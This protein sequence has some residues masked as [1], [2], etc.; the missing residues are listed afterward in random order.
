MDDKSKQDG[1]DDAKVDLNDPNE[2]AYA[3]QEAGVSSVEYKK[4]A[5]ESGSS[6]R[7]AIAAHIKKIKA[8]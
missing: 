2:V 3:A 5:T 8:S 4:Y 1:R 6:S 7:A